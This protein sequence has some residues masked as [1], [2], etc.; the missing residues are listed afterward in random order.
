MVIIDEDDR[1]KDETLGV[2]T[3]KLIENNEQEEA[4]DELT[5]ISKLCSSPSVMD[6]HNIRTQDLFPSLYYP[7]ICFVG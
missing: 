1:C 6:R 3:H 5:A 4:L 2:N 7:D